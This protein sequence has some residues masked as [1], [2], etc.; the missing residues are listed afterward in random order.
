MSSSARLPSHQNW[1]VVSRTKAA[2]LPVLLPYS[3]LPIP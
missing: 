3:S 1:K 2:A